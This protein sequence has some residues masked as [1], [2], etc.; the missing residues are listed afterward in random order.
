MTDIRKVFAHYRDDVPKEYQSVLDNI[1]GDVLDEL[2][3]IRK[4]HQ[5]ELERVVGHFL[6]Y[7]SNTPDPKTG[8][9][10]RVRFYGE[11]PIEA[12]MLF[13]DVSNDIFHN[14]VDQVI[15]LRKRQVNPI[16]SDSG[17]WRAYS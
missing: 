10:P 15:A 1:E 5:H 9:S 13:P 6:Y 4:P 16:I 2:H 12:K 7:L 3:E 11:C 14:A 8:I 17:N